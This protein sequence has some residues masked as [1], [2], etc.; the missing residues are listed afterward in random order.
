MQ[1][2][3]LT[4][5][6]LHLFIV[7]ISQ[8]A[9]YYNNA[10]GENGTSLKI[11]LYSIIN[12]HTQSSYSQLW[13][14][15]KTTDTKGNSKVWD[16][17]S[18]VPGGTPS[19]TYYY[20]G[21]QCNTTGF[22]AEGDCYNRE[23]SFPKSWWGGDDNVPMYTDLFHLVPTDGKVNQKRNNYPFGEVGTATWTSTNGSKLGNSNYTGYSSTVFEPIDEYKGDFARSYFYMATR[24]QN[25]FD[26]WAS[27]TPMLDG[28]GFSS[29][30]LNMLLDWHQQDPVSQK[31]LDRV[32]DI[33]SIQHNRNPFIDHPEFVERIWGG[34]DD[35]APYYYS[36]TPISDNIISTEF[37]LIVSLDEAC[38]VYYVVLT[39]GVSAPTVSQVKAGKDASGT[40]L[41]AGLRGTI[42][43]ASAD[44]NYSETISSLT[45]NASYDVYVVAEDNS[46][47]IQDNVSL[48]EVTL[49]ASS[50]GGGT[51]LT[52]YSENFDNNN[53]WS[54]GS[55]YTSYTYTLTS[56]AH[57]D[58]FSSSLAY[59]EV[60]D[61][62]S[63]PNAFRLKDVSNAYL[64]YECEG[65]VSSFSIMAARWDNSPTPN[66]TIRYSLNSG[67]TYTTIN[68]ITG[69]FFSSDKVYKQISHTFSSAIT[70]NNGDKIYIEF[71][72]TT[73]E[74]ML[75]DDFEITFGTA[76]PALDSE[77][78]II[79]KNSW[80]EPTDIDYV[81]YSAASNLTTSN[82]IE[83]AKFTIR[84]GGSDLTDNDTEST[85]LT[86]IS[87][88]I[89]NFDNIKALALFNGSTKV[90]ELTSI[91]G[92]ITF[93]SI[94]IT[95]SDEGS[96]D[97]SLYATFNTDAKDNENLK[98][99]I[100]SAT[101]DNSIGS[102]FAAANAGG[103]F[104]DD[105]GDNNKIEVNATKLSFTTN[106]PGSAVD[107][108]TNFEVEIEAV[109][110]NDNRDLDASN[111]ITMAKATGATGILSSATG[112]TQSLINGLYSWTD[113]QYNTD[114]NFSIEAQ[115]PSLTNITTG[116]ITCSSQP[117]IPDLIISEIADPKDNYEARF[118][119]IYN[120][121][122]ST[123]DFSISTFYLV[124]QA[125]GGLFTN[126]QLTG[127][128]AD[129]QTYVVAYSLTKFNT[130]YS[131]TADK[132]HGN[133]NGN[134]DDGYFLY[135]GGNQSTG[136]LIDSYG[137]IGDLG[138]G[139]W[140]YENCRV[141]RTTSAQQA[142][143]KATHTFDI[144]D[145][146]ITANSNVADMTPGTIEETQTL[147]IELIS[148]SA[149]TNKNKVNLNWKTATEIDNDYFTIERSYNAIDFED[150]SQIQAAGNSN[151]II[152]YKFTDFDIDMTNSIY[153]RLMQTDF[154]GKFTKSE[155]ISVNSKT[156][157]FS[158]INSYGYEGDIYINM[159]SDIN[160]N[161]FM[162]VFDISGR[163]LLSIDLN[164]NEG[165]NSYK[166]QMPNYYS[167]LYFIRITN[168]KHEQVINAK[169]ILK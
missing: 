84:D 59:K 158:L 82:S 70:N 81:S 96:D 137:I 16:M 62:N 46:S 56:P 114:E 129:K 95:A 97:F 61:N 8:P 14:D 132:G 159:N 89:Y 44:V 9:T 48:L 12:G 116:T 151:K 15:F 117:K 57:N 144:N 161:G 34:D 88:T 154:D 145:W 94:S 142:K 167:G 92:T 42:T 121:S 169:L 138:N 87:F 128:L 47:N 85:T 109:D 64:R 111:S 133:I 21:N 101:A 69:S 13:T 6:F 55:S 72:T 31:E 75:Y 120:G 68:T 134:G 41:A 19:Y 149:T 43:A 150:I 38:D 127:I 165:I 36:N 143:G 18:D 58:K 156:K 90:G 52:T 86:D 39:D 76:A 160:S 1:K 148:F 27:N 22:S 73:G 50:G 124:K 3:I 146:T 131:L 37:D 11:E 93:S 17:Y 23:H 30:A 91:S 164:L 126:V 108:A 49:S 125:N 28:N 80:T 77:S 119:E 140:E 163:L 67:S 147:P 113:V 122:G 139:T 123:I 40:L 5:I 33:Y 157:K 60:S 153:Y 107:N 103:A 20:T 53:Y 79:T 74:R 32:D 141:V 7:G 66:I 166:I 10:Q 99:T 115:N 29:W 24:Y 168:E 54:T 105:S 51:G 26:S 71:L 45:S 4:Y 104:T 100:N 78:D 106:K 118:V 112:L 102:D 83:L 63:A 130:A 65:T 2:F 152:S 98:F 136:T 110:V 25:V 162:E 155:I 135:Y 35:Y